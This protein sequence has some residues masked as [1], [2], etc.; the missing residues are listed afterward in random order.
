MV[1]FGVSQRCPKSGVF[2]CNFL[3]SSAR[4][5]G[6]H[7]GKPRK[8]TV[9][10]EIPKNHCFVEKTLFFGVQNCLPGS[11]RKY[12]LHFCSEAPARDRGFG[13]EIH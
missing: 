9:L 2:S 1:F 11:G 8:T 4:N 6:R 10:V 13:P 3:I 5:C 12:I 7:K